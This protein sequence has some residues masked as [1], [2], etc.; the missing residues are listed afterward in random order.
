MNYINN[1]NNSNTNS[2]YVTKPQFNETK[3]LDW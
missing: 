1:N 2:R 3:F